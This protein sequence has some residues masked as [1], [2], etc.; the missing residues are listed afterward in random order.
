MTK[1]RLQTGIAALDDLLGGGLLPGTLTVVLGATGIGKTQLGISFANEGLAQEGERG[2]LFD[3]TARGDSQSHAEYARR[4]FDWELTKTDV[5]GRVDP[6]RIWDRE[7]A[8]RDCMHLFNDIGRRVT[9]DDMGPD[10]WRE[11]KYEQAK[12]LDKA[13]AFFYGNFIH[14]VRRVVVDGVE[15]VDRAAESIQFELIE[16]V[17]GQ[18]IRKE[19]DWL[20]RDL[21]RV[22]YR[23]NAEQVARTAY[24]RDDLG[25]LLMA[26]SHEVMLDDLISRPIQ[27]GDVLS[28][29]NTIILMGKVR[30]GNR[31]SRALYVAKHR[32]SA[33]DESIVPYVIEESGLRLLTPS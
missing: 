18:I 17:Y 8:R 31:V 6:N 16:Y 1:E 2:I 3:L 4:L 14:G 28:N 9:A 7:L 25:C 29:A 12:R 19:Y 21:F 26:T 11:W 30:D 5:S 13:I 22:H 24:S 23:E 10:A 32:G 15:P 20:A 33:C 27:S